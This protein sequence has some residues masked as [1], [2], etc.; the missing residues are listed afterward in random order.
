MAMRGAITV[1]KQEILLYTL[2]SPFNS[3]P[4]HLKL[5][6]IL[7]L[8]PP[9]NSHLSSFPPPYITGPQSNQWLLDSAAKHWSA[10]LPDD[11][12]ATVQR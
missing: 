10:W 12:I 7:P 5:S 3:S 2:L 11:A 4:L 1:N 8:T 6:S 9:S